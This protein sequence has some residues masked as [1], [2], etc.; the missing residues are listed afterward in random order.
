MNIAVIGTGYVG[1]VTGTCFAESGNNVICV[2][3]NE[4]KVA[5]LRQGIIPIY[6]PE[7][8][9]LVERN[10]KQNRLTFTTDLE[11]A[12]Q[13]SSIILLALP[14]PPGEGGAADLKYI[15]GVANDLGRILTGY[16]VIVDQHLGPFYGEF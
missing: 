13:K 9:S 6:E 15:L 4:E 1:L 11:D 5:K 16:K 8:D 7:L 3:N 2:D 14:T 12:V 10:S